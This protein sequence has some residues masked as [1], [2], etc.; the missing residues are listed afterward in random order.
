MMNN[1]VEGGADIEAIVGEEEGE[2]DYSIDMD[3]SLPFACFI[4]RQ[5]FTSPIVTLCG[6]Y[7][8]EACA[9]R[10]MKSDTRCPVCQKQTSGVFNRAHKLIKQLALKA[11]AGPVESSYSSKVRGSSAGTWEVVD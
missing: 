1:I 2:V 4:C 11:G 6:H 9:L 7:F 5:D 10:A 3:E 8:C